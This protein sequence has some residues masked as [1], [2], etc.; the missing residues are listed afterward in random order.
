MSIDVNAQTGRVIFKRGG[1]QPTWDSADRNMLVTNQISATYTID[2]INTFGSLDPVDRSET[3]TLGAVH[4]LTDVFF[5]V[6]KING[7][8]MTLG[9]THMAFS[10][11]ENMDPTG[12]YQ[13]YPTG[14]VKPASCIWLNY[15]I[16]GGFLKVVI[17]YLMP[18][19]AGTPYPGSTV[20]VWAWALTY[21]Y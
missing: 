1:T 15:K 4:P 11:V 13:T 6:H 19:D 12:L 16:E 14:G 9:G 18:A 20:T 2:A 10:A 8:M 21:D 5:G 3:I 7:N 17:H